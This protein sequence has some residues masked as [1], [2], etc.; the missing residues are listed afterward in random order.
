MTLLLLGTFILVLHQVANLNTHTCQ[1]TWLYIQIDEVCRD[2]IGELILDP[3]FDR[4]LSDSDVSVLTYN[5]EEPVI[6]Y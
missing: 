2:N 4:Y 1:K 6:F 5:E 3:H